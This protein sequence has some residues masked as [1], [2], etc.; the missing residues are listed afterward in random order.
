MTLSDRIRNFSLLLTSIIVLALILT[1]C[2]ITKQATPVSDEERTECDQ[3]WDSH[4]DATK[5]IFALE[6]EVFMLQKGEAE[7]QKSWLEENRI[8]YYEL[9][10]QEDI[11]AKSRDYYEQNDELKSILSEITLKEQRIEDLRI[12]R[13]WA[14]EEW[15]DCMR[16]TD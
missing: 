9:A 11:Q 4:I 12:F 16:Y 13:D 5:E 2:S 6:R 8:S 7:I 3:L 1:S 14:F 10:T 15:L